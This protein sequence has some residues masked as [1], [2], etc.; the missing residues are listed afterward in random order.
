MFSQILIDN[1][2]YLEDNYY[3]KACGIVEN[4][5]KRMPEEPMLSYLLQELPTLRR[6][7]EIESDFNK[8]GRI[9][10]Y[11]KYIH[12]Y[13]GYQIISF[14]K[15]SPAEKAGLQKDDIILSADGE[16]L[17]GL[18]NIEMYAIL[19]G[20]VNSK[21]KLTVYRASEDKT[22]DVELTRIKLSKK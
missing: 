16:Q 9:G 13:N 6:Y 4:L 12:P 20:E 14:Y 8:G 1:G 19:A 2:R 22:F 21:V 15:D 7:K 10:T 11:G 3:T 17:E 18:E 5:V